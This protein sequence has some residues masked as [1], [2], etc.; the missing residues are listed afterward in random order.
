MP[1]SVIPLGQ[2]AAYIPDSD[3][4]L[5]FGGIT[6]QGDRTARRAVLAAL[7]LGLSVVWFDGYTVTADKNTGQRMP[8]ETDLSVDPVTVVDYSAA[9]RSHWLNR[10]G[11]STGKGSL[12]SSQGNEQPATAGMA[13]RGR[14][15]RRSLGKRLQAMLQKILRRISLVLRGILGWNLVKSEIEALAGGATAPKQIIYGD[16][17]AM[18]QAWHAVR[19]WPQTE[20][21]VLVGRR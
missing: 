3:W 20:A 19:I 4:V 12:Q 5:I 11:G 14:G 6:G 13:R 17:F 8:L 9:E 7:E 21:G 18:T 16:E 10:I 2:I 1:E 15:S